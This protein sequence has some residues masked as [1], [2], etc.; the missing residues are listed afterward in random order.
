MCLP[1]EFE[2]L[3]R[4]ERLRSV[5]E[6]REHHNDLARASGR[7]RAGLLAYHAH[8]EEHREARLRFRAERQR[9]DRA[10]RIK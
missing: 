10:E 4:E 2:T 6:V 1:V 3:T 8:L 7:S 9:R 5:A